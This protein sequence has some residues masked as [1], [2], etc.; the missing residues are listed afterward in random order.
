MGKLLLQL[1]KDNMQAMKE[2]DTVKKGVLSLVI[3]AIALAEKEQN[4]TLAEAD[5]LAYVQKE[6]KQVK[7][8]LA[9]TPSD[10]QELIAQEQRKIAILES[11]LPQQMSVEEI[12]AAILKIVDE[13]HLELNKKAQ[14]VIMKSMLA[15]YKG[16]VDGKLVNQILGAMLN[17]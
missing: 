8:S 6:L 11:Y 2:K 14:G 13:Q 3:A 15:Q 17:G 4:V 9:Q 5:E 16:Q 10:R 1:R 7:D 12:K